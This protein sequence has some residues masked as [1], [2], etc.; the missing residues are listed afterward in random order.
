MQREVTISSAPGTELQANEH[1]AATIPVRQSCSFILGTVGRGRK[2]PV[3]E[4]QATT[5]ALQETGLHIS[6]QI[7]LIERQPRTESRHIRR[8]IV[9]YADKIEHKSKFKLDRNGTI[10]LSER[11]SKAMLIWISAEIGDVRHWTSD[12]ESS[13][14]T[15][16]ALEFSRLE[17][18][19]RGCPDE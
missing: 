19:R 4:I 9:R 16:D 17:R 10:S 1:G 5:F 12:F 14:H 18:V 13:E 6:D 15:L 3:S 2:D 7:G 8:R 11:T